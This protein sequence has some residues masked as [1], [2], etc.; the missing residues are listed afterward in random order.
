[1]SLNNRWFYVSGGIT[2]IAGGFWA[3]HFGFL[4]FNWI[5]SGILLI[6]GMMSMYEY[7]NTKDGGKD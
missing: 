1:M 5:I 4:T 7:A 6:G 2:L 3:W